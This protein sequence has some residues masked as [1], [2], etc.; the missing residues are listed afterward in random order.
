MKITG[1]YVSSN[2][3]Q[4]GL[5]TFLPFVS[6]SKKMLGMVERI[7]SIKNALG[8]KISGT[9][10]YVC[11]SLGFIKCFSMCIFSQSCSPILQKR[12]SRLR[13]VYIVLE[14]ESPPFNYGVLTGKSV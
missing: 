10:F 5:H 9:I 7:D 3:V 11:D 1:D 2:F 4:G 13:E 12:T 6:T 8:T 14:P